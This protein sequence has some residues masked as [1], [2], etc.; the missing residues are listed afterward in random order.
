[1]V[2]YYFEVVVFKHFFQPKSL[3]PGFIFNA[4]TKSMSPFL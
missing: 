1:M 2:K 4:E 3:L